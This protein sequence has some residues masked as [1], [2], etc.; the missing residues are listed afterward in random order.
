MSLTAVITNHNYGR[1]LRRCIESAIPYCDEIL[2]YDDGSTDDSLAVLAEYPN[3]KVTHRDDA[4]G[5]PI[6]GSNLGIEDATS[7]HLIFL[8]ADNYLLSEPPQLDYDYVFAPILVV[9]INEQKLVKWTFA[10]YSTDPKIAYL[11][12][13]RSFPYPRMPFPWGGVWRTSWLKDKRWRGWETTQFAQDF[14]TA[15]D[16]CKELPTLSYHTTKFLAFRK[17]P[18]QWSEHPDRDVM[19]DEARLAQ[20]EELATIV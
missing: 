20:R 11:E 2:V 14:R 6:W 18:D 13:Q 15:I 17:H 4:T 3:V 9:D 1:F 10:E 12:F 19:Y 7:T 16:W 5:D 8:D